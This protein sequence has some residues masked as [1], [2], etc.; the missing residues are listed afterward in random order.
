MYIVSSLLHFLD[1]EPGRW[2]CSALWIET[3]QKKNK[4]EKTKNK[5][6]TL[7]FHHHWLGPVLRS[8]F[9]RWFVVVVVLFYLCIYGL[10]DWLKCL[11]SINSND[12]HFMT[13]L[14]GS[15]KKKCFVI[16]PP[17]FGRE[18]RASN[19]FV[20]FKMNWTH[21]SYCYYCYYYYWRSGW[22]TNR[23][24]TFTQ[25]QTSLF[26]L[27][28]KKETTVELVRMK[29]NETTENS[30]LILTFS[31]FSM[32]CILFLFCFFNFA[33]C[34]IYVSALCSLNSMSHFIVKGGEKK[35][36]TNISS[37]QR[38]FVSSGLS[39]RLVA[40]CRSFVVEVSCDSWFL[41]DRLFIFS[42]VIF[43]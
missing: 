1:C 20:C 14:S 6:G 28:P 33:N 42:G 12:K 40:L 2:W 30:G 7:C 22:P 11:L 31:M 3:K 5:N 21:Y 10:I 19:T 34:F 43:N 37:I 27:L 29:K 39:R 17:W 32:F 16:S 15:T 36:K 25:K 13:G 38:F 23:K 26:P 41:M 4:T 24:Y 18:A 35:Q 8:V 9:R